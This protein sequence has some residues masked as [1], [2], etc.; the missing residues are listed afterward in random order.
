MLLFRTGE[1]TGTMCW[2]FCPAAKQRNKP[3]FAVQFVGIFILFSTF[4]VVDSSG[5]C[6]CMTVYNFSSNFGVVIGDSVALPEP[7][8]LDVSTEISGKVCGH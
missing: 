1:N 7:Y 4:A 3:A 6:L 8:V 5:D 2:M